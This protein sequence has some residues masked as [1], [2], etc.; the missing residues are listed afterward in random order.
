MSEAF[1]ENGAYKE[2]YMNIEAAQAA[3]NDVEGG[4][5]A[6]GAVDKIS[7]KQKEVGSL[8]M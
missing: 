8:I 5:A 6:F 4:M 7:E 3:R 2:L 1:N